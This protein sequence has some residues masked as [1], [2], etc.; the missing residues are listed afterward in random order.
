MPNPKISQIQLPLPN[1]NLGD[2]YDIVDAEARQ[3]IS[4]LS[5]GSYFLGVTTTDVGSQTNIHNPEVS[6]GGSAVRA[7]NGNMVIRTTSSGDGTAEYVWSCTALIY[8]QSHKNSQDKY[9]Y[10]VVT[11]PSTAV[12]NSAIFVNESYTALN[13]TQTMPIAE[14]YADGAEYI[15]I[16]DTRNNNGTWVKFGDLSSLGGLA[17]LDAAYVRDTENKVLGSNAQFAGQSSSVTRT[18]GTS[19]DA[20][21]VNASFHVLD[22]TVDVDVTHKMISTTRTT[23]VAVSGNGSVPAIISLGSP[24]TGSVITSVSPT[25]KYFKIEEIMPVSGSVTVK[26]PSFTMS[27]ETLQISLGEQTAAGVGSTTKLVITSA[28]RD[29][30]ADGYTPLVTAVG[31]T[32]TSGFVKGYPNINTEDVLT[33]VQVSTQPSFSLSEENVPSGAI[34]TGK[35]KVAKN[36]GAGALRADAVEAVD[37]NTVTAITSL[38]TLTAAGQTV[39]ATNKDEKSVAQHGSITANSTPIS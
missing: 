6:I 3:M 30:A 20:L 1:G 39:T 21:G 16:E 15:K 28:N 7:T 12:I 31:S 19:A 29:T 14:P 2:I 35:V 34:P 18:G 4:S 17:Y 22:S 26:N 8:W 37:T 25:T 33:G 9:Y 32:P 10:S 27:G 38:G 36:V 23:D 5:G 11:N 24:T 13:N